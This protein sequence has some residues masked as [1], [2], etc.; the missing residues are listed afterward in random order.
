MDFNIQREKFN[1][2]ETGFQGSQEHAVDCNITLP[3]YL[4]D[5]MKILRCS[6]IPGVKSHQLNGDRLNTECV[7]LVRVIYASEQ[8][9]IH[10][11]EQNMRFA[12]QLEIKTADSTTQFFAGAKP[13]TSIITFQ[14]NEKSKCM[15]Q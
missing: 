3:E 6:C 10:C 7:C 15:V 8:G 4:P 5:I 9:T 12:K 11:Y 2:Y 1:L 13:I 14:V